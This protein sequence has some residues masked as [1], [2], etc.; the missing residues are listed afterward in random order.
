[1]YTIN[2][3]LSS[4]QVL[5]SVI[6]RARAV[7]QDTPK[8]RQYLTFQETPAE[9]FR[10]AY[11][12]KSAVRM[13]SV[14]S[15]YA[16]KP[17][18]NREGL[19]PGILSVA[20]LGDR[21][22]MG[23]DRLE[24]LSNLLAR[25]NADGLTA[26]SVDEISNFLVDDVRE[27]TL[28]P[29]KRMDKVLFDLLTTGTAEIKLKD[30]PK[31]VQ[32]LDIEVPVN[33][34]TAK[35]SDKGHILGFIQTL[36]TK[37]KRYKYREIVMSNETFVKY[38]M[39]SDEFKVYAKA[40]MGDLE[41][42]LSGILTEPMLSGIF[43]NF[44]LPAVRVVSNYVRTIADEDIPLLPEGKIAIIP[45]ANLGY[46]RWKRTYETIDR[47]PGKTYIE[48]EGGLLISTE[49][50]NEG[51]FTEYECMWV[52]EIREARSVVAVDLTAAAPTA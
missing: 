8:W 37:Y 34:E 30:N 16:N 36:V 11:G 21:F 42:K 47:V 41:A 29:E 14:I 19:T 43:A 12:S 3:I 13:G 23:K 40:T 10:T 4:P 25:L 33:K 15:D 28:A 35:S 6:D 17:L 1:M 32:V 26:Q 39:N 22:Q 5:S 2:D 44:G 31:G 9:T 38:F 7:E 27:L 48:R 18:R 51:R 20:N 49:R 24:L 45:S 50:T 46:M 52:P